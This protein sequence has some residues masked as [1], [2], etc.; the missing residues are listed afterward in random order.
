MSNK[1]KLT[2]LILLVAVLVVSLISLFNI[3]KT[4]RFILNKEKQEALGKNEPVSEPPAAP[5]ITM[6]AAINQELDAFDF[7][8]N[9][10]DTAVLVAENSVNTLIENGV[11]LNGATI[12]DIVFVETDTTEDHESLY[13]FNIH[14][15]LTDIDGGVTTDSA[16]YVIFYNRWD[17][18]NKKCYF[19]SSITDNEINQ[20]YGEYSELYNGDIFTTTCFLEKNEFLKGMPQKNESELDDAAFFKAEAFAKTIPGVTEVL[21]GTYTVTKEEGLKSFSFNTNDENI[22]ITV[23]YTY[24]DETNTWT[25]LHA[26]I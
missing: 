11:Y 5:M 15:L 25:F 19:V 4:E 6:N 7:K 9:I 22:V 16:N 17:E 18:D 8:N 2:V 14:L 12:S 10:I 21:S 13:M 1:I 3:K 24:F 20:R 23:V 26:K